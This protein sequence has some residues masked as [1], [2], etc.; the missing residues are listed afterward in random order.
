LIDGKV[1]LPAPSHLK[2]S[3]NTSAVTT[4]GQKR[5]SESQPEAIKL[6]RV[7]KNADAPAKK[8]TGSTAAIAKKMTERTGAPAKK[9]L[10]SDVPM[11]PPV[12]RPVPKKAMSIKMPKEVESSS[13]SILEN[14]DTP[15]S[16]KVKVNQQIIPGKTQAQLLRRSGISL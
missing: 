8:K 15:S 5:K 4:K 10:E 11:M 13:N 14:F 12:P 6:A 16:M 3:G 7:D 9:T 1:S 2:T